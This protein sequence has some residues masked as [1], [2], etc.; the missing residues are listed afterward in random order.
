[1]AEWPQQLAR[2]EQIATKLYSGDAK[3]EAKFQ[4]AFVAQGLCSLSA[5]FEN[6]RHLSGVD[7]DL[8]NGVGAVA[9]P[10]RA[11]VRRTESA[12]A[13]DDL[14]QQ[15]QTAADGK[16]RSKLLREMKLPLCR[17]K[18]ETFCSLTSA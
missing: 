13:R 15:V 1:M 4:L 16:K 5:A 18:C 2:L 6:Q 8:P 3:E 14:L 9:K 10:A 17:S 11:D 12:S 7:S